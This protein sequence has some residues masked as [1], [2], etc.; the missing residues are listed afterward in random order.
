MSYVNPRDATP[1]DIAAAETD[2]PGHTCCDDFILGMCPACNRMEWLE[3]AK[4]A[5]QS[6]RQ[7]GAE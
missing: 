7:E 5:L 6:R 4:V 2:R 1:E 3:A